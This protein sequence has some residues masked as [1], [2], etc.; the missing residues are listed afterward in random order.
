MRTSKPAE[1]GFTLVEMLVALTIFALL[2]AA[3]VGLLRSSVDTHSAV[4]SKLGDLAAAARLRAL[5]ANDL[6]QVVDRPTRQAGGEAPA[7]VGLP[8]EMRFVRAGW[9]DADN[10]AGPDLRAVRWSAPGGTIVRVAREALDGG[11]EGV[12]AELQRELTAASFRY[13]GPG[14]EW[15]DSWTAR[16]TESPLPSAVELTLTPAD[17]RPM[18]LVVALPLL[19]GEAPLTAS[20]VQQ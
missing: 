15:S 4:E 1:A 3:G 19:R 9:V 10:L 13:R 16:Q 12:S 14:G 20:V 7:F 5:L 11:S 2:S 17:G 8:Q 18:L 6:V